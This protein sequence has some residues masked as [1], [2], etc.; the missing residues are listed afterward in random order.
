MGNSLGVRTFVELGTAK[1]PSYETLLT[2][3]FE[4]G[5]LDCS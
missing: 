3:R 2:F 4:E 5:R 1:L